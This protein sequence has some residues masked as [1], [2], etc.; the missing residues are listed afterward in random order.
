M[1]HHTPT[2]RLFAAA[3]AVLL[4]PGLVGHAQQA[5]G[6]GE[7]LVSTLS[8]GGISLLPTNHPRLPRDLSQLWLVPE[9]SRAPATEVVAAM[10]LHSEGEFAK[11][12]AV[13]SRPSSH[14]GPLG[15]YAMYDAAAALLNLGQPDEA[16]RLF[17][18]IRERKPIGFLNEGAAF[19]EG[20]A[21]EAQKDYAAAVSIYEKLLQTKVARPDELLIRLGTAAKAGGQAA[22]AADVFSRV[23]YEFPLSEYASTA[24]TEL[25]ALS[26]ALRRDR[27]K[28]DLARAQ[29]LFTARQ[30]A[31]ART[32]YTALKGDVRG[33]ERDLVNMR[34]AETNYF[35]KR[36]RDA[37]TGLA[38][39]LKD[40]PRQAEALYF[41]ALASRDVG[42]VAGYL[43]SIRRVA[44]EFP[45]Q[46]WAEEALNHLATHHILKDEDD[47][48]DQVFRELYG[49]YPRGLYAERAAWKAGW[50]AYLDRRYGETIKFF[51]RA[52][53]DFPRSDYRP[54]WLYWSGRSH[55]A[56]KDRELAA[57]RFGL[58]TADYVNSYYGRL[59][60]KRLDGQLPAPRVLA[61]PPADVPAAALPNQALIQTLISAE[62]YDEALNELRYAQRT[63]GDSAAIQATT[64][65]ILHQQGLEASGSPRFSLL[66]GA[67]TAMRRAYPQFLA[68]G[69]EQLPREILTVIFPLDYWDLIRKYSAEHDLD[70]YLVAALVS[71][72]STFAPDVRS[73]ANA[74]GLMQLLPSTARLQARKLK[75]SYSTRMLTNPEANIRLGTA[76][77]ADKM[78]EFG[79]PHLALAS[80]N[81]G[82]AAVRQWIAE[83]PGLGVEEF[84]DDIPY[85]ETQNY[86]KRIL[87]TADDYRRLYGR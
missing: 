37:R 73:S 82:E 62:L 76:Y 7:Q 30:Y 66:R 12:L 36:A 16:R 1:K 25:G 14:S 65:W 35:L 77:F 84:I 21:A 58:V 42:D 50:R 29:Q 11:A 54:A 13:L 28:L 68:A 78:E 72:E 80:Y 59:A 86:V 48:A 39:Y 63:S 9:A 45:R 22:K 34:I 52:A 32:A 38:P 6:S 23:Y 55:E 85:P 74:V 69:G 46:T 15:L 4:L 18:T 49:K 41:H 56:L 44:D 31:A 27:A 40:S 2:I 24:S 83:R 79:A 26:S 70:P 75:I 51:E 3:A 71:Q 67:I 61:D 20:K 5:P 60:V 8:T 87:G 43:K 19:G 33:D 81:A 17:Q 47:R 10:R 53:A 64:A 57:E